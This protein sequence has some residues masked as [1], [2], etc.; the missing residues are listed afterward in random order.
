MILSLRM[1]ENLIEGQEDS[2]RNGFLY[3][4]SLKREHGKASY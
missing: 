3:K 2:Q 4:I 1:G